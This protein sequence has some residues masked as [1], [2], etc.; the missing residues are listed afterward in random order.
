V[1]PPIAPDEEERDEEDEADEPR[2]SRRASAVAPRG[3]G[4]LNVRVTG[5]WADIYV[6]GAPRG[7][8]PRSIELSAGRHVL[9]LRSPGHPTIRRSVVIRTGETLRLVETLE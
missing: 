4:S 9:E 7:D 2:A 3:N 6:D 5:A 1:A 8:T